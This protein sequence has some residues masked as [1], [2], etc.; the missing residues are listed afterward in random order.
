MMCVEADDVCVHMCAPPVRSLDW[1]TQVATLHRAGAKHIHDKFLQLP[2][3]T[4]QKILLDSGLCQLSAAFN[5]LSMLD[6]F[7]C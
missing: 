7:V 3:Y 1:D 6:D 4:H 5:P 2:P